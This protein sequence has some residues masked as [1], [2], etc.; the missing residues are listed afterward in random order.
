MP[1]I[2]TTDIVGAKPVAR[3]AAGFTLK[4]ENMNGRLMSVTASKRG[5]SALHDSARREHEGTSDVCAELYADANADDKVDERDSIER[6]FEDGHCAD[7]VDGKS[8]QRNDDEYSYTAAWEYNGVDKEP[9]LN[10]EPLE[11]HYVH[12]SQRS[13]K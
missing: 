7:D 6:H 11:F 8:G 2:S 10:K 3:A 5:R 1:V 4:H 13:Y 9:I 12:P